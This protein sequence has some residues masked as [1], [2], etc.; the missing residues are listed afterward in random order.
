MLSRWDFFRVCAGL[1]GGGL[2][3]GGVIG[4]GPLSLRYHFQK[5]C[6]PITLRV[7]LQQDLNHLR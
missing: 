6:L 7:V 5:C 4:S 2:V 3:R 1:L